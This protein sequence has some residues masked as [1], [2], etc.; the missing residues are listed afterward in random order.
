MKM[1]KARIPDTHRLLGQV[2]WW[3][4]MLMTLVSVWSSPALSADPTVG[5]PLPRRGD[6]IVVGG[7]FFHSTAPVVLWMDPGGY[8]AYRVERRF[9]PWAKSDWKSIQD[10]LDTPNRYGLRDA[11]LS[12]AELEEVRG[13]GWKLEQL[14]KLVDQFVIHYDVCGTSQRCFRVLHDERCLSV[15]FMLDIDGTIYQTMDLK[16]RGWHATT[17]NSRS[18]GIEIAQIGAYPPQDAGVLDEWYSKDVSGRVRI[19]LPPRLGT[20]GVRTANF[21]GYPARPAAVEGVVQ[22]QRLKQFDFTSEQY[23]SLIKLTATLCHVFPSLRCDYPKDGRGKLIREKLPDDR[24][25]QY[26]GILGHFHV[27]SNKT[28]PGPAFQWDL[29]IDGAKRLLTD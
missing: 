27:Q 18:V 2:R 1:P 4:V 15:H 29:V 8:D 20:G 9:A 25:L 17:S 5:S 12:P 26:Q 14:R 16:E 13:G 22:G 24:L 6:E 7:Q 21:V 28:D 3:H 23:D 11:L 19:Q 10:Q